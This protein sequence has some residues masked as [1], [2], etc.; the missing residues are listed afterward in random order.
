M[1]GHRG[2]AFGLWM[3]R[4][5]G[6]FVLS[7]GLL[8]FGMG[9]AQ[10]QED[11]RIPLNDAGIFDPDREPLS[12][13]YELR[14][15][16][17]EVTVRIR[18]FRG[19]VIRQERLIELLAGDH[20]FE[21]DGRDANGDRLP[22]GNYELVFEARFKDG[23]I[24]RSVV[25]ARIATM[26]PAPGGPAPELLPPEEHAYKISGS[27]SSFWRHD[28]ETHEDTGQVRARTRFSYADD[29]RRAD[30]V[31]DVIDTYPGGDT[32]Y[33]A[34]QAFVEQ[35]WAGGQIKGVFRDSLG[36]F[37]DPIKLFSDFKSA[38]KKF[39]FRADQELGALQ[40]TG[41]A[42]TTEGD[43]ETEPSGAA[44]R[45]RYG[46]EDGWRWGA[47]FTHQEALLTDGS[48]DRYRN[49]AMA[50]DLQVPIIEPLTFSVEYVHTEDTEKGSDNGYTALAAFDKG[51]LRLTG[52]Y[53]D[54]GEDFFA[55]FAD[56]LHGVT[57]NARGIEVGADVVFPG[58]WRY[59]KNPIF[60]MRSFDLKRHSD[61]ETL[62]EMDASLRFAAGER[63]TFFLNWYGQ[64]NDDGTTNTFLGTA[65]HQ[66]N[67][68]WTSSL[69][70]NRV[71][72]EDSGTWR[73]TLDTAF[74][75]E[76]QTARMA[77][78]WIRRTIDA[79]TLSPYEETNLR[80]D[81]DN[82]RWGVQL[83]GR[84][85]ENADDQGINAFGRVE[86]RREMLHRYQ[87]ITYASIGN[88]S[89]FDF[90]KQLEVGMELRF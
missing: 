41:L 61:D 22:E 64:E 19:Q 4:S 50:A 70:V 33:D 57:T 17:A 2:R 87:V 6:V 37:E 60:T 86:Y 38:R 42:F 80:L 90:E 5:I 16:A 13:S 43:V 73:F 25:A 65:T 20:T 8:V 68:W 39:G 52:G 62:R 21:W 67:P 56:P 45:L 49:Q 29:T 32:N 47:G 72:A 46:E 53:I 54:L 51:W 55:D 9:S 66:W 34:S 10:A 28:G 30:G 58:A 26:A 84:Y 88:R 24:G 74:R 71:D 15:D 11:L 79:S 82:Q 31:L 81:W 78:E 89:A 75:R 69:Q 85:S 3:S 35:R 76:E 59:F 18:D 12:V 44:A 48:D 23:T 83:Q 14:K 40:A 1:D 77:L 36:A 27:V 7:V 63:D